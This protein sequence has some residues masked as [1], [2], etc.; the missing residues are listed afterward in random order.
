MAVVGG[1]YRVLGGFRR[2]FDPTFNQEKL[3][4]TA[5]QRELHGAVAK[6]HDQTA[7][8]PENEIPTSD[9]LARWTKETCVCILHCR[10]DREDH[11]DG[12][13]YVDIGRTIERINCQ[14]EIPVWVHLDNIILFLGRVPTN[15]RIFKGNHVRIICNQIERLLTVTAKVRSNR[16]R[17]IA[18]QRPIGDRL[19]KLF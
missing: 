6:R 11:S 2:N 12:N 9:L 3:A 17:Q 1:V 4:R 13:I 15:S 5:I 14:R 19:G 8:R 10:E 16:R 18:N 7:L